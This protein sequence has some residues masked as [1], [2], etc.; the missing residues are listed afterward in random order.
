M[1]WFVFRLN[2]DLTYTALS[3]Y[4]D[5]SSP[6]SLWTQTTQTNR[7]MLDNSLMQASLRQSPKMY[8]VWRILNYVILPNSC[9]SARL[10]ARL[11]WISI[12]HISPYSANTLTLRLWVSRAI[13][14][15]RN[16]TRLT[17]TFKFLRQS[18]KKGEED[19]SGLGTQIVHRMKIVNLTFKGAF[20]EQRKRGRLSSNV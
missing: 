7:L 4:I 15:Q 20:K 14:C 11:H 10:T 13:S 2:R 3:C 1:G 6:I 16:I 9:F 18:E 12:L 5:N 8:F 19:A 17:R